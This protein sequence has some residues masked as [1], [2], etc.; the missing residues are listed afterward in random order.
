MPVVKQDIT[1]MTVEELAK[2]VEA[3]REK[4]RARSKKYYDQVIKT[5]PEKYAK[6]L[7]KC[8]KKITNSI[9]IQKD[10]NN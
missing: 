8:K 10:T 7:N 1:K 5:D 4:R 3:V 6:F 2:Y 9:I